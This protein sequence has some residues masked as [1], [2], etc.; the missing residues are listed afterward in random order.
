[1]NQH[2]ALA[3][4]VDKKN[5]MLRG[6]LLRGEEYEKGIYS[7]FAEAEK[8]LRMSVGNRLTDLYVLDKFSHK[9]HRIGEGVHDS[10]TA[11]AWDDIHY[12]NLQ[13]GDGGGLKDVDGYGYVIIKTDS[14]RFTDWDGHIID[15]R[16]KDE[17][18]AYLKERGYEI[19]KG[20]ED[21]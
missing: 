16:F 4:F 5:E 12:S 1:M 10:L 7:A 15:T 14:G 13:N 20:D 11:Y 18:R 9:I 21:G 3:W 8:A 19:K 6:S 17:I 2:E